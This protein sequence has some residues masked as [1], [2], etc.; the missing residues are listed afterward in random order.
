[1][2][3]SVADV[4]YGG[5]SATIPQSVTA[6]MIVITI[7]S[8]RFFMFRPPLVVDVAN[9][10]CNRDAMPLKNVRKSCKLPKSKGI[11]I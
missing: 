4:R 1:L 7:A 10:H 9:M 6:I 3:I 5:D 11:I 2:E 8:I